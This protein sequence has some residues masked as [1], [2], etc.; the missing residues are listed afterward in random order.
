MIRAD[1]LLEDRLGRQKVAFQGSARSP[2]ITPS[3]ASTT[4]GPT[5]SKFLAPTEKNPDDGLGDLKGI[6]SPLAAR[7]GGGMNSAPKTSSGCIRFGMRVP[8]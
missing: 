2:S 7:F 1:A 4:A 8:F 6:S 3:L 5:A